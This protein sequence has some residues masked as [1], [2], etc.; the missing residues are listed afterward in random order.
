MSGPTHVSPRRI[1]VAL[2]A[3]LALAALVPAAASAKLTWFGSTLNHDPA[4]AGATCSE[5]GVASSPCTH[6]GSFY[7]GNSGRQ[8]A[9]RTGHVIKWRILSAAPMTMSLRIV[10]VRHVTASHRSGQAKIAHISRTVT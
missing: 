7:P 2:A 5:L 1:V 10:K 4:N 9:T 8:R 6:V 3:A